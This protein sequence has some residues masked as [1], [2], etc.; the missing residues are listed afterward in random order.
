METRKIHVGNLVYNAVKESDYSL[1]E[2]ARKIGIS[3]QKLNGWLKKDDLLVKD[4]FTISEAI[5]RDLVKFFCL[6]VEDVQE[7]KV[8]LQIEVERSKVNDVL[9]VIKDKQL[10]NLLKTNK[11]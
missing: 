6:P 8:L 9:K 5:D 10:Y 2:V 7:T 1:S 11:N 3:R 4:L